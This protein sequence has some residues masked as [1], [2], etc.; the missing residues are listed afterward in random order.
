MVDEANASATPRYITLNI[1][2]Y[3]E[4]NATHFRVKVE[5]DREGDDDVWF[6]LVDGDNNKTYANAD[7]DQLLPVT[8]PINQPKKLR[9]YLKRATTGATLGGTALKAVYWGTSDPKSLWTGTNRVTKDGAFSDGLRL[10]KHRVGNGPAITT[11]PSGFRLVRH[12]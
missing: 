2:Q 3:R 8:A 4:Q 6:E 11:N 10:L 9:I 12:P 5:T 1:P 7:F